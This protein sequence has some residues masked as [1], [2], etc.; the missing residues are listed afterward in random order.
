MIK[1]LNLLLLI[2]PNIL[3]LFPSNIFNVLAILSSLFWFK[4]NAGK[5]SLSKIFVHKDKREFVTITLTTII[6]AWISVLM[7]KNGFSGYEAYQFYAQ[8]NLESLFFWISLLAFA[9]AEEFFFRGFLYEIL[10]K[11]NT[12]IATILTIFMSYFFG[13][14][15]FPTNLLLAINNTLNYKRNKNIAF[16]ILLNFTFKVVA[17]GASKSIFWVLH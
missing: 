11:W 2:I 5:W 6:F 3:I 7:F 16:V 1:V 17:V 12:K 10:E 15:L 14:G 8:S 4:I 9:I 13:F